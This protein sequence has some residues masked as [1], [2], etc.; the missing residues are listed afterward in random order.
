MNKNTI[1]FET[2]SW[3]G[4]VS[5]N[6]IKAIGAFFAYADLD[7]YKQNLTKA[8]VYSYKS[9]VYEANNPSNAFVF[10]TA[11]NNFLKLCYCLQEK[12]K[13]WQV[14]ASLHNETVFHL[15]SLTKEEY[16]DPFI[17]FQK[18][19][20]EKTPEEFESFLCLI[21]ELSTSPNA[22]D[23]YSD[24]TIPYIYLIKMLDAVALMKERGIEKI[25]ECESA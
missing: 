20:D 3:T 1:S 17:V 19:F 21:L 24:L 25:K 8:V 10:Y 6:P 23:P 22:Q 4:E 14:M 5:G 2:S 11:M 15:S 18:A 16:E 13:K 7:Y 12:S 9:E